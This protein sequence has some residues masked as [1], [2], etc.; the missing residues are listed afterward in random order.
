[1]RIINIGTEEEITA[2]TLNVSRFESLTSTDYHLG[3]L[4]VVRESAKTVSHRGAL[5]AIGRIGNTVWDASLYSG[6]L[7][8][9][10]ALD[11]TLFSAQLLSSG[12]SVQS[13]A[14]SSAR[15]TGSKA[16]SEQ[17]SAEVS[18]PFK[19]GKRPYPALL[20][21]GMK[22]FVQ[23]PYDCILATKPTLADHLAWLVE[24]E[25]Y[26]EAWNILNSHPEA[27][28]G[29]PDKTP[30]ASTPST[31]TKVQGSLADFFDDSSP[32]TPSRTKTFYSQS[33][34]EKRHI[35]G[36][37]IQQLVKKEDWE[38]AG[39]V[40]GQV[41]QTSTA[42]ERW[43]WVFAEANKHSEISPYVPVVPLRP[44]I[45]STAYEVILGHY[46]SRDRPKL[47]EVLDR[48]P[49]DLFDASSIISA[50]EGKLKFGD[51]REDTVEDGITGR[52]WRILMDGLAKLYLA[53]GRAQDALGCYIK[54]QDA[55]V[56]L[57]LIQT[58]HLVEAVAD[59][60]P[61]LLLLRVS[62]EQQRDGK[63]SELEEAS[64][65]SVRLLVSE[66]HHGVVKP[67][68]VVR[69][70]KSRKDMQ[71]FLFFY[72]R[73][74]WNG[75]TIDDPSPSKASHLV[76][77][78]RF[79]RDTTHHL[80]TEGKSLV[81][82]FADTALPLFAE[83]ERELLFTFLKAS[84]SYTLSLATS[85]CEK[86]DYV[87]EQVY[88]LAKEGR[89]KRA[90]AVIIEKLDNASQAIAFAKEQDDA[91]LWD[92]LLNYS[93]KRPGFVR[94]LLEEVGTTIDPITLVR[95]IPEGLEIV[96][97]KQSLARMI[98][99]Y[100]LQDSIS[101]GVARVLRGEVATGMARL[102]DGQK[103]GIKF[104][105]VP[106]HQPRSRS[107]ERKMRKKAKTGAFKAGSCCGCGEVFRDES[108]YI[109]SSFLTHILLSSSFCV[110]VS[111]SNIP[112]IRHPKPSRNYKPN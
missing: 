32:S 106:E 101:E 59:D 84:Q 44:P 20:T 16:T 42:W 95:R 90:L 23:S 18:T 112:S 50:I 7:L 13:A 19:T 31:P 66:A 82:D 74:L 36:K 25:Q 21:R 72:F 87:P 38:K 47:A 53:D 89:T 73:A 58:H 33:E 2:D 104:S 105:V 46:V 52:D 1:M 54:L 83:Y 49:I 85:I 80:A 4:P 3:I 97:L 27:G 12:A 6:K 5:E 69:Q 24:H 63:L 29:L 37:W 78:D 51:V 64:A 100:E 102:R 77:R 62:K 94:A 56:A 30:D 91:D 11:A 60:I 22:V 61:G 75:D 35:G 92:D 88:L 108:A 93:M 111:G 110:L 41:L 98:R 39:R 17:D 81:N 57:A 48:W 76:K 67:Q 109:S 107:K 71:P 34:N 65:D 10:S 79:A 99:E 86:R 15:Q 96:G 103:R 8:G 28:G 40:C 45:S 14:S 9:T 43:I 70:L 68:E 55:E 26:E